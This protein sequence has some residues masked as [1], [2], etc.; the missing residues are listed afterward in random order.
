MRLA[1]APLCLAALALP[2]ETGA[3][4]LWE[5]YQSALESNAGYLNRVASS[6]IDIE[7]PKV[8]RAALL[9]QVSVSASKAWMPGN[10]GMDGNGGGS[11]RGEPDE[12]SA[13]QSLSLS[14]ALF[15]PRTYHLY[16]A[17]LERR[18]VALLQV[19]SARRD[20]MVQVAEAYFDALWA[21]Q[22]LDFTSTRLRAV[23]EQS[24]SIEAGVEAGSA[25]ILDQLRAQ[26][27]LQSV[28]AAE[29]AARG[30]HDIAL[31]NLAL[32]SGL[33]DG[34]IRPLASHELPPFETGLEEVLRRTRD[35]NLDIRGLRKGLE[36]ADID[37]R[38]A[39]SVVYPTLGL[40]ASRTRSDGDNS[41]REYDSR[42][43]VQLQW[44]LFSGGGRV[45]AYRQALAAREVSDTLLQG[46]LRTAAQEATRAVNQIRNGKSQIAALE[47]SVKANE[48]LLDI[49]GY[50]YEEDVNVL[51]D[52]FDAQQDLEDSRTLLSRAR[53]DLILDSLR[54]LAVTGELDEDLFGRIARSIAG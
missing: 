37:V 5:H 15:D 33:E 16:R 3:R 13:S 51:S 14:Q 52:V 17:S 38:A 49:V 1:L 35:D 7:E 20:L 23:T 42:Y 31:R 39:R 22:Q 11:N 34:D 41:E 36:A 6:K 50:G 8:R 48:E 4:G 40:L 46:R 12:E 27:E 54:L 24:S 21:R 29:I 19:E 26:A 28:R 2:G 10:S 53:L 32:V 43:A 30:D 25:T 45:P 18:E 9:P 47:A 44:T